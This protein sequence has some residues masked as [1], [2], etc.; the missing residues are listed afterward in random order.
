MLVT[1]WRRL[2]MNLP[3][4]CIPCLTNQFIRLADKVTDD[5]NLKLDIISTGLSHLSEELNGSYAPYITG[6]IYKYV[7]ELVDISDPYKEEKATFNQM[8]LYLIN[9]L[10]LRNRIEMSCNPLDTAIRLSIAGNIIDF[11]LGRELGEIDVHSSIEDSLTQP[12]FGSTSTDMGEAIKSAKKILFLAD[13]A[14]ETAFDKLLLE[15]LPSNK[16]TYVVK[17]GPCV[18]D[19]TY[20]DALAV[21]IDSLV[22]IIDNGAAYQ[23]TML[24]VCSDTFKE[25]F[26]EADLIISKGQANFETLS[27][28]KD[29]RIFFLLRAK[30]QIIA[31]TIGCEKDAFVLLDNQTTE[32]T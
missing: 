23:G 5:Q 17:G 20:E 15:Y 13:N 4:E 3:Y 9:H 7:K 30:C 28:C 2:I 32:L 12:L 29:K 31:N 26:E 1:I 10:D 16:V 24:T 27:D 22:S 14:G 21:G 19:A 25:T 6:N 8:A 18:N 11:S